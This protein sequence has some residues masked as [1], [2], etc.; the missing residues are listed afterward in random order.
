MKPFLSRAALTAA[1]IA[2]LGLSS[3][4]VSAAE[5]TLLNVSYDVTRELYK[6]I[7]QAFAKQ[8][9][10]KT[11]ER[12]TINQSHGG[13]SKQ[14]RSV[15]DGLEADVVTM[16]QS[17]DIDLLASRGLLPA[18]WQKRL[19][20]ASA[21]YTSTTVFLV[22]KGNPKQIKDWDDL[23][24]PGVSV[25]IP[26][27][28]TSG[29]GRF[30]YLAAWGY[31]L[32]KGGDEAKAKDFV[33][34]VFKNAPVLPAGGRDATTAFTQRELGDVLATFENEVQLIRDELGGGKEQF[35]V[36]YPS[37][38]VLAEPP[39]A[40]VDKV[41][42]KHGSQKLA[43]AY[44]EFLYSDE[45]QEIAARHHFR[46]RSEAAFKRHG[47]EFKRIA[48]FSINDTFGGWKEAQKKHFDDGG[49]FDQIYSGKR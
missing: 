18:D 12:V 16:N 34:K 13:S 46:P 44:L 27:P 48:L 15:A 22:R 39:V 25:I 5:Q 30:T 23:A 1:L 31:V 28:K 6:D 35:E 40:L 17:N 36:V 9:L 19:P 43:Q 41:V 24:K 47:A 11:G 14:A 3:A 7:N 33:T 26:N 32:K 49:L 10:A 45:G 8:W 21:P 37:I 2:S 29:N 20:N 42:A 38:S 4:T